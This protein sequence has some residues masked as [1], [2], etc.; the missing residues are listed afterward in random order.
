MSKLRPMPVRV[1]V[2]I[3]GGGVIGASIA[4]HL[5]KIGEN[6][7]ALFERHKL[8]SGTTWH[9][10][11][12]VGQLRA[13]YN[14]TMLAKYSARLYQA[15]EEE[16]GQATGYRRKGALNIADSDGLMDE[17]RRAASMA[18]RFGLEILM[19]SPQQIKEQAPMLNI[20]GLRGG[21]YIPSEGQADPSGVTLALTKGAR[22]GGAA[23]FEDTPIKRIVTDGSRV[24]GVET[25]A[26]DEIAA[27]KVVLAAGLW[28]RRLAAAAG[29]TVPVHACE[30]YY[31]VTEPVA[32]LPADMPS[33]RDVGARAYY[34]EDAGKILLGCFEKEAI[35][36][37]EDDIPD[38]FSFDSFSG[39]FEHFEP[40]L[41]KAMRRLPLLETAGIQLFFCGPE[42]FTPDDRYYVGE[43]P[44]VRGLF[45]SAGMNSIGIQSAGGVGMV[46][47]Q[48]LRDG[49]PPMDLG[50]VDIARAMPFQRNR[51]YL[52][53]R[54]RES[55]GTLFDVH[56]P[57]KQMETARNARLSPLHHALAAAGACFGEVAG[58]ERANWFM[59][60][61]QTPPR[62]DYAFGRQNWFARCGE[63]CAAARDAAVVMDLSSFAKYIVR[64]GDA[65][66]FLN[67]V[68]A[69]NVDVAVGKIVYT[70][71]LNARGGIEA[72]LTVTRT[73]ED[74]FLI[75]SGVASQTRDMAWL[76]R[77]RQADECAEVVDMT[78][79]YANIGVFG[80]DAAAVLRAAG[81]RGL[82]ENNHP[83]GAMR[84]LEVGYG[85]AMA[86]RLSY[87]GEAGFELLLPTEFAENAYRAIREAGRELGI[88][89]AGMHAV[90]AMRMEKARRHFGD[91]ITCEDT[92]LEAG[93]GFAVCWDKP[94]IGREALLAQKDAPRVKRLLQFQLSAGADAPLMFGEEPLLRDG[95][96]VGSVTS[97]AYGHRIGA[98]LALA[99]AHH[100]DGV[101]ND[102][103]AAGKWEIEIAGE[104][105]AAVWC[106]RPPYDAENKR[107]VMAGK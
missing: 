52:S 64:G 63:E 1:K 62:Y 9:A 25:A 39:E 90:D 35:P 10:A 19:L 105:Q 8:T 31:I 96:I 93:L 27:D 59:P 69:N 97:A 43:T 101:G 14:M 23:I 32:G 99:Y 98:S 73:A 60:D 48:W 74:E 71:W 7:F 66:R 4:Y 45:V 44:E 70:P 92:P 102:W 89:N 5:A 50:D 94:F 104:R 46:M 24:I 100:D 3:V 72:D 76:R 106:K 20:D 57:H 107:L 82:T 29:V 77:Q 65:C 36:R 28:S 68:C 86:L 87:A 47:A 26:G 6:D 91:D 54:V 13:T 15:L 22:A 95:E 21:V 78:S 75:L 42:S 2:A 37:D 38:N 34:K 55:L 12:L 81:A 41:E 67:R 88:V 79:A 56:Y 80:P 103:C 61:A 58:W 83:F 40:I 84:Q 49:M 33:I 16:T 85:L 30:H 11:G 17:Y 18:K 51:R 53:D